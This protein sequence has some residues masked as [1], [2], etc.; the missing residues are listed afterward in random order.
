MEKDGPSKMGLVIDLLQIPGTWQRPNP[1]V[2]GQDHHPFDS[3]IRQVILNTGGEADWQFNSIGPWSSSGHWKIVKGFHLSIV[4]IYPDSIA[5]ARGEDVC[6][7]YYHLVSIDDAQMRLKS[8]H[9]GSFDLL[10]WTRIS[11][12][13]QYK[14]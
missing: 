10:T 11:R 5:V 13:R 8:P 7:F 2:G 14:K 12:D 1:P 9:G 6:E 3:S 4:A